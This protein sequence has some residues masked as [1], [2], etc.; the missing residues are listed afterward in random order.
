MPRATVEFLPEAVAEAREA[1]QWYRERNEAAADAFLAKLDRLAE[2][3][4]RA[5][6]VW[7]K[8]LHATQHIVFRGFPYLLVFRRRQDLVEVIAVAHAKRRPGYWK[9]RTNS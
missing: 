8:Y 1:Q 6:D 9:R 2:L 5:P 3:V 4:A 7:L